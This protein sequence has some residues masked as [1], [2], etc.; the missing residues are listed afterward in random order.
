[1]QKLGDCRTVTIKKEQKKSRRLN[2]TMLLEDH[3]FVRIHCVV[4]FEEH[5]IEESFFYSSRLP[6]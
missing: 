5:G 4:H 3:L 6:P 1:M 2:F